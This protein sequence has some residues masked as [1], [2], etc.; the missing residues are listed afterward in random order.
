MTMT[1]SILFVKE[2]QTCHYVLHIATPRLCGEPGFR[3]RADS[4]HDT[5]IRCREIVSPEEYDSIDR[6]LPEREYPVKLRKPRYP[7]QAGKPVIDQSPEDSDYQQHQQQ[8]SSAAA[9]AAADEEDE[10]EQTMSFAEKLKQELKAKQNELVRKALEKLMAGN[11]D[12]TAEGEILMED[13]EGD[14]IISFIDLHEAD[15]DGDGDDDNDDGN[16]GGGVGGG[17]LTYLEKILRAA[18]HNVQEHKKTASSEDER[19]KEERK[20]HATRRDEL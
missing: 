4:H 5:Y 13:E 12:L 19:R 16:Q 14:V 10:Q 3:S 9:A 20:V 17:R 8:S 1:D 15:D 18:G 11:G 6:D 2:T 7:H